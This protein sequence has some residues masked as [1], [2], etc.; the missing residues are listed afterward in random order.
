MANIGQTMFVGGDIFIRC[1]AT[2]TC[3]QREQAQSKAKH[4]DSKC[5]MPIKPDVT[6]KNIQD[7]KSRAQRRAG[8]RVKRQMAKD[9]YGTA[10]A[11]AQSPCLAEQMAE[12]WIAGNDNLEKMKVEMDHSQ[13]V[14]FG[15]KS[16]WGAEFKAMDQEVNG[17]FGEVAGTRGNQMLKEGTT[18]VQ[19]VSFV[20]KPP[21]KPPHDAKNTDFSAVSDKK[22]ARTPHPGNKGWK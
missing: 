11:H 4:L 3:C 2:M 15:G 21:C 16:G 20:C 13:E 8:G 7:A 22:S 19:S 18:E 5:P 10:A 9:P 17:L 1:D 6:H 14:K 12:D